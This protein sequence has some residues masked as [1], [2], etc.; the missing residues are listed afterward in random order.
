MSLPDAQVDPALDHDLPLL[1][2]DGLVVFPG[3]V[4]T[5]RVAPRQARELLAACWAGPRRLATVAQRRTTPHPMEADLHTFGTLAELV[6]FEQG[7]EWSEARV[8]GIQLVRVVEVTAQVPFRR[9]TVAQVD[10]IEEPAG[11]GGLDR[12]LRLTIASVARSD[13]S[14]PLALGLATFRTRDPAAFADVVATLLPL[15]HPQR[16]A[17]LEERSLTGRQR[18]LLG[19]VEAHAR[20]RLAS[21]RDDAERLDR[22]LRRARLTLAELAHLIPSGLVPLAA[23]GLFLGVAAAALFLWGG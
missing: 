19:G 12:L 20:Q 3:V 15:P 2:L 23:V 5:L 16:Q 17:L 22:A 18:A 11:D 13:P 10:R 21:P 6:A 14:L 4:S 9:A 7:G 8:R 1:P